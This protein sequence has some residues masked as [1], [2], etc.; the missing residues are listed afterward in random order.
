MF[1]SYVVNNTQAKNEKEKIIEK[2]LKNLHLR[3]FKNIKDVGNFVMFL[4]NFIE[5]ENISYPKTKK[6]DLK[7]YSPDEKTDFLLSCDR[8]CNSCFFTI[9]ILKLGRFWENEKK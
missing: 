1:Y 4:K 8:D 7:M 6:L 2:I 3:R 9:R 5:E